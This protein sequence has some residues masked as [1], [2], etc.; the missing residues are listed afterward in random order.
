MEDFFTFFDVFFSLECLI[1]M[2]E[3]LGISKTCLFKKYIWLRRFPFVKSQGNVRTWIVYLLDVLIWEAYT[4]DDFVRDYDKGINFNINSNICFEVLVN[5]TL[6]CNVLISV[7]IQTCNVEIWWESPPISL[8]SSRS[9]QLQQ[10]FTIAHQ[11]CTLFTVSGDK[12]FNA[13]LKKSLDWM[14]G[15]F[16][17]N[18]QVKWYSFI[19][20][21]GIIIILSTLVCC[22]LC[23]H[24]SCFSKI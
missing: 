2:V 14:L 18:R 23:S 9:C 21:W 1:V 8:R 11:V 6:I 24:L 7:D 5:F 3:S 20:I 19:N 12:T 4:C 16:K 10:G 13:I 17:I 15:S 22:F